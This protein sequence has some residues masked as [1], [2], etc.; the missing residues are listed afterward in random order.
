M[1]KTIKYITI[2]IVTAFGLL[3]LFLTSSILLNLFGMQQKKVNYTPFVIWVNL[4]CSLGYLTAAYG[5]IKSK[6][7][8][9]KILAT[10][11]VVLLVTLISF[12]LYMDGNIYREDTTGALVFRTIITILITMATYSIINKK[13]Y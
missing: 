5:I 6:K 7:W 4:F 10:I 3:T 8:A 13:R 2:T 1:Q 12:I 9:F 11:A